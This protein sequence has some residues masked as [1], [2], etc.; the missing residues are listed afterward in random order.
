MATHIPYRSIPV[1][2]ADVRYGYGPDS[3]VQVGVPAG[4]TVEL[5]V[6]DN[7]VY[8]RHLPKTLD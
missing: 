3:F 6:S 2:Q 7:R 8:P 4:E 5:F 1:D